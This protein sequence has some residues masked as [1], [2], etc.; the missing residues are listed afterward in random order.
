MY[1]IMM[2]IS[3]CEH[4]FTGWKLERLLTVFRPDSL[5]V[6]CYTGLMGERTEI[7]SVS[8]PRMY[9]KSNRSVYSATMTGCR[10]WNE[11]FSL[12]ALG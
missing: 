10:M 6:S 11:H 3:V 7:G 8:A 4:A 1:V 2:Y 12:L 5:E 9:T